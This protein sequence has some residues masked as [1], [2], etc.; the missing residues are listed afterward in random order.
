MTLAR[1]GALAALIAGLALAP[2]CRGEIEP[3]PDTSAA[4]PTAARRS[5][6]A[7]AA[8]R[9]EGT[10]F[11]GAAG[12]RFEW[13][14]ISA[15]RLAELVARGRE[16]E[17]EAYLDWAASRKLTVVRVFAIAR[18]LFQLAPEEGRAAL[19]RVLELAA[20]RT[21]HVEIVA[22]VDTAETAIDLEGHVRSIG[23]IAARHPNALVEIANEPG[24]S[25]QSRDVQRPDRLGQLAAL[26]PEAVPVALGSVEYDDGLAAADYATWHVPRDA[27]QDGWGHVLRVADGAALLQ[28]FRK[29]L[30]SDEPI[31]AGPA[32]SA[33]RR[34]DNPSR[35]AAAAA[36]TRFVGMPPTFHYEGGLQSSI[37][38]AREL[39]SFDGWSRGLDLAA[40]VPEQAGELLAPDRLEAVARAR[41]ARHAY[42]RVTGQEAWVLSI[43][44]A[45]DAAVE[46]RAP[47][48][49]VEEWEVAGA[50]LSRGRRD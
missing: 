30:V 18:H 4:V 13:R 45:K 36:L 9:V 22:L 44:P 33:G 29:P 19:P 15:F 43:D 12:A 50:R 38:A 48:R 26:I 20:A 37:P 11:A 31:G 49:A 42:G 2:A 14:G 16:R 46:W 28:R 40:R 39:E 1:R 5:P 27:G 34:D 8:L 25:T 6:G 17:V 47:W 41:G 24:H 32:F 23:E 21:M 35:F 7:V 10:R 3:A